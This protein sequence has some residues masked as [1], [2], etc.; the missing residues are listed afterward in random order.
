MAHQSVLLQE[1]VQALKPQAGEAVLDGTIGSGGHALALGQSLGSKGFLAGLDQDPE[2]IAKAKLTLGSLPCQKALIESNF[3]HLAE[4]KARENW[5]QFDA[6]LLDLGVH[7]DQIGPSG[8][9]FSFLFNE[10]LIMTMADPAKSLITARDVVNDWSEANLA[11]ILTGFGEEQFAKGIAR[12]IVD[13]RKLKPIETTFE[14]VEIIKS[15]VPA[16]YLHRRLHFATKTFQAI[17]MAVNDELGAL[18]AVLP[19][20]LEA[21]NP[22][23]RLGI[24]TFHSLEAR[25]VKKWYKL[26]TESE[27]GKAEKHAIKPSRPE[28]LANPRSRSATLRLFV[29][30]IWLRP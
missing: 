20:A 26:W 30:K 5:P 18:E 3:R 10:P 28:V 14:L 21:L 17:R 2:A 19:Q 29:K 16:G 11:T 7:S 24:I 9:G 27:V 8:R 6:I 15:A 4:I 1:V 22:G 12:K 25:V 23:G 13:A